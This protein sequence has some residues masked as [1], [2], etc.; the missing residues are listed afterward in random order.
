MARSAPRA[1]CLLVASLLA[2]ATSCGRSKHGFNQLAA[3]GSGALP[4]GGGAVEGGSS[5]AQPAQTGGSG[6]SAGAGGT[7]AHAGGIV[8]DAPEAQCRQGHP[9]DVPGVA[10]PCGDDP[11]PECQ[12]VSECVDCCASPP[13]PLTLG[14]SSCTEG[15]PYLVWRNRNNECTD[16]ARCPPSLEAARRQGCGPEGQA[17][18]YTNDRSC[19]CVRERPAEHEACDVGQLRW[20]C[21]DF[22]D[23]RC[24]T[25]GVP[26]IGSACSEEGTECLRNGR[27][28]SDLYGRTCRGS[29]WVELPP[30]S[31][32][33]CTS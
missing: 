14:S 29:V 4:D 33:D 8:G 20:Y 7:S 23:Q 18:S 12:T 11:R 5:G 13:C 16:S 1:S 24:P 26:D 21:G 3:G 10:C 31:G 27:R 17:C 32:E 22:R 6:G 25:N 15:K 28:C 2:G 9:C 30:I 19:Y